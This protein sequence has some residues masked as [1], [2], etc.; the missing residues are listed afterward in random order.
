[1]VWESPILLLQL[2][3]LEASKLP[4]GGFL[5][6]G[7]RSYDERWCGLVTGAEKERLVHTDALPVI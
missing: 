7:A 5:Y 6:F 3:V 4:G 2:W 1:M